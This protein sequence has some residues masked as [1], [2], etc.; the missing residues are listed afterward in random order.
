MITNPSTYSEAE[1]ALIA[2]WLGENLSAT[3]IAYRLARQRGCAVSRN[4]IIGIVHRNKVLAAIGLSG[5]SGKPSAGS[6]VPQAPSVPRAPKPEAR[7]H[8]G[9][10]RSKKEARALDPVFAPPA[11]RPV[12]GLKPH[13]YDAAARHIPLEELRHGECRWPVN[14]AAQGEK[15][16][17]CGKAA[18]LS[19]YCPHHALRAGVRPLFVA[20]AA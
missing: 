3:Q 2:D 18:S 15:H 7:L 12:D 20:E 8:P 6:P 13:A 9:N 17:F 14:N 11:R 4:A 10:I 5:P 19:S 1:I 16:L